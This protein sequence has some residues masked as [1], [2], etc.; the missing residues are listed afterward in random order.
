MG[1]TVWRSPQAISQVFHLMCWKVE[2]RRPCPGVLAPACAAGPPSACRPDGEPASEAELSA[3]HASGPPEGDKR[4]FCLRALSFL[5]WG[6]PSP[7]REEADGGE[8]GGPPPAE[9]A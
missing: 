1:D 6:D 3:C 9:R 2:G 8:G 4:A 7:L 5:L